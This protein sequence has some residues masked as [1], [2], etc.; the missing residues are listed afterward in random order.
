MSSGAIDPHNLDKKTGVV[1]CSGI[2]SEGGIGPI[3]VAT[4]TLDLTLAVVTTRSANDET[5]VP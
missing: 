1:F 4:I 3:I 2:Q 5:I